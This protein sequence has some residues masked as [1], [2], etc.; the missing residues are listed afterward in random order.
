MDYEHASDSLNPGRI[1]DLSIDQRTANAEAF[2][3]TIES[4]GYE[5]GFYSNLLFLRNSI[6]GDR[7]SD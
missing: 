2:C 1:K 6:N 5:A 3:R 7:L 4:S